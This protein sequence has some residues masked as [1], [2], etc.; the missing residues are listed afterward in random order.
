MTPEANSKIEATN[1]GRDGGAVAIRGFA[2]QTLVALLDVLTAEPPITEITLEPK[3]GND[4]FD[5]IWSDGTKKCAKQVKSTQNSFTVPDVGNW[6]TKMEKERTVEECSLVLVG[7]FPAAFNGL[8]SY[9]KVQIERHD[10]DFPILIEAANSGLEQFMEKERLPKVDN[11][12][13]K[14]LVYAL[15]A[16]LEELSFTSRRYTRQ[17]F[18]AQ[19]CDWLAIAKP[20]GSNAYPKVVEEVNELLSCKV[21]GPA[22]LACSTSWFVSNS[23]GGIQLCELAGCARL[24]IKPLLDALIAKSSEL[25]SKSEVVGRLDKLIGCLLVLA[26]DPAWIRKQRLL[27]RAGAITYPGEKFDKSEGDQSLNCLNLVICAVADRPCRLE[28]LFKLSDQSDERRIPG[29]PDL[30]CG[31]LEVDKVAEMKLGIIEF[32]R[33]I[34][35]RVQKRKPS[36][37]PEIEKLFDEVREQIADAFLS[38]RPYHAIDPAFGP[39]ISLLKNEMLLSSLLVIYPGEGSETDIIDK[40]HLLVT[41]LHRLKLELR[42]SN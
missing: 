26:I 18:C 33:G 15:I 39:Y 11:E 7:S 21:L 6:A 28:E 12:P 8:T 27:Y 30:M 35:F 17:S 2:V 13:R 42:L 3:C 5:F 40:A 23:K 37:L 1:T 14:A 36:S 25:Q 10:F 24:D 16:R 31:V 29:P 20:S 32:M 41:R 38:D 9:G 22:M 19:L 4:Q 34:I